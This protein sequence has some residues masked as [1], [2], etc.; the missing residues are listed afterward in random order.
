MHKPT[1]TVDTPI[2]RVLV[3]GIDGATFNV[4][5]PLISTGGLP[6]ISRL[7]ET[8][9][10]GNLE[11]TIPPLTAPAWSSFMTGKNPG[12]HG[13]LNFFSSSTQEDS[14]GK[15]EFR[16]VNSTS[17]Y[18]E[19]LWDILSRQGYKVG[20]INV[21]LT[22]PPHPVNG[23]MITGM[24]TPHGAD[25][26]TY[27]HELATTLEDYRID[28]D[29]FLGD[30]M[31]QH[32]HV[33]QLEQLVEELHELLDIRIKTA[34]RLY[35]EAEYD[36]FMVVFTGT[37]RLGHFL[38]P[39]HNTSHTE[40]DPPEHDKMHDAICDYYQKLDAGIGELIET[41]GGETAVLIMSDHGMGPAPDK[42]VYINQ[43]LY[44]NS[45]LKLLPWQTSWKNP[46]KWFTS[47]GLSRD[48]LARLKNLIPASRG[49]HKIT[50]N[51]IRLQLPIDHLHTIA[52]FIS[53]YMSVGAIFIEPHIRQDEHEY[54][55]LCSNIIEEI[56]EIFDPAT[57]EA[58]VE[59]AAPGRQVY[60]GDILKGKPDIVLVLKPQYRSNHRLGTN[61]II[62]WRVETRHAER[63]VG[64]HRP[65]GIFIASG[66]LICQKD[67]PLTDIQ[68]ED[69]AP[70][71]LYLL[72]ADIPNDM[73]GLVI[74]EA[75]Q[76][77]LLSKRK[78]N[79][80]KPV[81]PEARNDLALSSKQEKD[82]LNRLRDLGYLD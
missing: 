16:P 70:T 72:N 56:K 47:L 13:V 15:G 32:E 37:D 3:I 67:E 44:E 71:I 75:V 62:K 4:L 25:D 50:K 27:P 20:V 38:W 30:E 63:V 51:A 65:E 34:M 58:V 54:E 28:L 52:Y 43:W 73:D 45:Y 10:H 64:D 69:I 1:D 46:N 68:I 18:G 77:Q 12:K 53:I 29:Y 59:F 19:T 23:I 39:Y 74:E 82:I 26:F 80:V 14:E 9:V 76:P 40:Q 35:S 48:K 24:L 79:F 31:G 57:S 60:K 49:F 8:G 7:I 21:P 81:K 55:K 11:S 33:P 17:I 61:E 22:Y 78:P 42:V 36:F 5:N 6:N 2:K 66:P 41:A